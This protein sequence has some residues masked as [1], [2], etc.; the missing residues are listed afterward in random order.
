VWFLHRKSSNT[1]PDFMSATTYAIRFPF[2]QCFIF[3]SRP[4]CT[5]LS[6][7]FQSQNTPHYPYQKSSDYIHR[8]QY[9]FLFSIPEALYPHH[10][11]YLVLA[12]HPSEPRY[13]HIPAPLTQSSSKHVDPPPQRVL[14]RT[15]MCPNKKLVRLAFQIHHAHH[16]TP[17]FLISRFHPRLH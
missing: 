14:N 2:S 7:T 17:R 8:F 6:H 5:T 1:V 12:P 9:A 13:T 15:H 16:P 4:I 10:E 3:L 11:P